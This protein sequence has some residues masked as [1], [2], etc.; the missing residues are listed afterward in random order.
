MSGSYV[1]ELPQGL[2]ERAEAFSSRPLSVHKYQ[3]TWDDALYEKVRLENKV[4]SMAVLVI[5][6]IYQERRM[7]TSR[8]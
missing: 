4:A 5:C 1:S 3:V 6:E 8:L 2:N 7:N